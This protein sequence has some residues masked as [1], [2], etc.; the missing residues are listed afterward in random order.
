MTG[1]V[2]CGNQRI[3]ET[4]VRPRPLPSAAHRQAARDAGQPDYRDE[5]MCVDAAA[6]V[7]RWASTGAVSRPGAA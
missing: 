7:N 1:C 4:E 6:C 5:V 3:G 2:L